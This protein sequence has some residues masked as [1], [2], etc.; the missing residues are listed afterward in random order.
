MEAISA[1]P[2]STVTV[3]KLQGRSSALT[4]MVRATGSMST[5]AS[6]Q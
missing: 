3:S 6:P 4:V 5:R 2:M 1:V